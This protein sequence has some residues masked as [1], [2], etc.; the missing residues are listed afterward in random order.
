MAEIENLSISISANAAEAI[1]EIN[2]LASA[3]G[4]FSGASNSA[5]NSAGRTADKVQD[6]GTVTAH[7]AE[8]TGEAAAA[9]KTFGD[10]L[11]AVG[12]NVDAIKDRFKS[13][14]GRVGSFFSMI[15]RVAT[16]RAIR[17]ALRMIT[18]GFKEGIKNFY[19]YSKSIDGNFAKS[20]DNL[21]TSAQYLKNSL[22][23]LAAPL[24]EAL[25]P[26]LEWIIDKLVTVIVFII[27]VLCLYLIVSRIVRI[28]SRSKK[29]DAGC[30]T[31]TEASCPLRNA[32]S[33]TKKCSVKR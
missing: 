17:A 30:G 14:T 26:A 27:F 13:L 8:E 5:G 10:R 9:T 19:D 15:K 2:K 21:A 16:Y 20:M 11:K 28:V 3:L 18:D 33:Q 31:C 12:I 29:G 32:S 25:S 24:V 4:K 7:E 6:L 23:T 22:G 1:A